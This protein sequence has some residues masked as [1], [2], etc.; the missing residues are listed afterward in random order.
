MA[1]VRNWLD[2]LRAVVACDA[3]ME[4]NQLSTASK[5]AMENGVFCPDCAERVA[6]AVLESSEKRLGES[7]EQ[8]DSLLAVALKYI[9]TKSNHVQ[10]TEFAD[11]QVAMS[12]LKRIAFEIEHDIRKALST[13]KGLVEDKKSCDHRWAIDDPSS[14]HS[15]RIRCRDC[16]L[17]KG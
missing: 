11:V 12:N 9:D 14:V 7:E 4:A 16:G 1:D 15:T 6:K 2:L 5:C 3:C 17:M 8:R 10:T 13:G